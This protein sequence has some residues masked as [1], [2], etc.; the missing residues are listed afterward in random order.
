MR[1]CTLPLTGKGVL[2]MRITDLGVFEFGEG[3]DAC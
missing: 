2:D 1:Q 3:R